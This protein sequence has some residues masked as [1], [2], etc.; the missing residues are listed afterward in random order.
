MEKITLILIGVSIGLAFA[1]FALEI[2]SRW[3]NRRNKK[4]YKVD[5][6][7]GNCKYTNLSFDEEPCSYCTDCEEWVRGDEE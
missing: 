7:C 1:V 5:P 6:C 2:A 3:Y 4:T